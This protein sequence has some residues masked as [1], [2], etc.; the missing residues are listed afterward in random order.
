M[1]KKL[2]NI[3]FSMILEYL[4]LLIGCVV[5]ALSFNLFLFPNKIA[6]G[7][8]T[9]LSVVLYKYLRINTAYIQWVIN[10]PLFMLGFIKYGTNFSI[11][12]IW[13]FF[14]IPF[15]ILS[16]QQ[17]PIPNFNLLLATIFGG[18]GTGLGLAMVFQSKS[19]VG[20]FSLVAQL[21][22]DYTKIKISRLIILLNFIVII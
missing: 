10:I 18:I 9:G 12:T 20:G 19:T 3:T 7:G 4:L 15:F 1:K 17:F 13:G 2:A 11:K 16:T 22:H 21:L 6:S 5:I 8:L 14:S